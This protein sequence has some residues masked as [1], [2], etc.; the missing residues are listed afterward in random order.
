M[1]RAL[2]LGRRLAAGFRRLRRR[3][4]WLDHVV[5]AGVRFDQVDAWRLSAAV[6][7]YAFLAV[8]P[9]ALLA[10]ALLGWVAGS[11]EFVTSS[12]SD[13]L[14]ENLPTLDVR[15]IAEARYTAGVVGLVGVVY[16]GLGWVDTLRS[17]ILTVWLR[18][19]ERGGFL[20]TKLI[21]FGVLLALGPIY[22][23]S[24]AVSVLLN[25]GAQ[26][27]LV[28]LGL[29]EGPTHAGLRLFAFPV[30]VLINLGVFVAL[31]AGLPRLRMPLRGLLVPALV[32]AVAF[33]LLKTFGR[34]VL[35]H[36]MANPAYQV[37]A[38]AVGVLIFLNLLNQLLLYCAALTATGVGANVRGRRP[39]AVRRG[40]VRT[41][42]ALRPPGAGDGPS[43]GGG[44]PKR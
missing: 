24:I 9:L 12:L 22:G 44:S 18:D 39:L 3:H 10:Y 5:R 41:R 7:Y 4:R 32:G 8:F 34:L 31:L 20:I 16:A 13:F 2:G 29:S 11:N 33:E 17:S 30:G 19:E 40:R 23:L 1:E 37:V 21:D 15:R 6:T 36:T 27:L 26:W 43:V 28:A 38:S 14:A 42:P 25:G 35:G